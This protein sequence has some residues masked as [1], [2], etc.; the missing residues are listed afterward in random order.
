[1]RQPIGNV[2]LMK[3]PIGNVLLMLDYLFHEKN[4]IQNPVSINPIS[5]YYLF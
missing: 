2:L 5:L 3:Q 4:A 1:M